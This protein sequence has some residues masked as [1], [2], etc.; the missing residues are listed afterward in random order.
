MASLN[1]AGPLCTAMSLR[2]LSIMSL[3]LNLTAYFR[4]QMSGILYLLAANMAP[5]GPRRLTG[6]FCV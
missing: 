1:S 6:W 2:P 3:R 4:L 5:D